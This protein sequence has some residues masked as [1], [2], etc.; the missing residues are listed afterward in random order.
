MAQMNPS[1]STRPYWHVD[2]KWICALLLFTTLVFGLP[3]MA[4]Y[5]LTAKGPATSVMSYTLAGLT[6]PRGIDSEDGLIEIKERV[7]INKTETIKLAGIAI[8]FTEQDVNTLSPRQLRLKVF[9]AFAEKFYNQGAQGIAASQ[10]LDQTT[11]DQFQKDAS[12]LQLFT[13]SSHA[14]IGKVVLAISVAALIFLGLAV[15]FSHRFGRLV[16]PGVV[17]LLAGLP[18]LLFAVIANQNPTVVGAARPETVTNTGAAL[19][20]F[21]AFVAPLVVPYFASTY[22]ALLIAGATLLLTALICKIVAIILHR[23]SKGTDTDH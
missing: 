2:A 6:S 22:L 8:I 1:S 14:T 9:G 16:T 20:T 12:V 15:L 10:G 11:S 17:F 7:R 18:G 23:T 21:G 4:L 19:A 13:K 3:V 5:R